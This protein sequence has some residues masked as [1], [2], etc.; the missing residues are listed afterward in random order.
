MIIMENHYNC[1]YMYINKINER[2]Y[3]GQAKDFNK[4]HMTHM[5]E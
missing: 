4:R 1:I 3:V 2:K 5:K